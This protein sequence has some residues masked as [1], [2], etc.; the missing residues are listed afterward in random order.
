MPTG[1]GRLG[2]WEPQRGHRGCPRQRGR[3]TSIPAPPFPLPC[4]LPPAAPTQMEDCRY[5]SPRNAGCGASS[6][7]LGAEHNRKRARNESEDRWARDR[8]CASGG[9]KATRGHSQTACGHPRPTMTCQKPTHLCLHVPGGATRS[10]RPGEGSYRVFSSLAPL[11]RRRWCCSLQIRLGLTGHCAGRAGRQSGQLR[12]WE[13]RR[14]SA[15][16]GMPLKAHPGPEGGRP[17]HASPHHHHT[18]G[19]VLN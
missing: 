15:G 13:G 10:P 8:S 1:E 14:H 5:R 16:E 17:V 7:W 9:A 18:P 3:D 6:L 4:H 11:S 19:N 2:E 12:G